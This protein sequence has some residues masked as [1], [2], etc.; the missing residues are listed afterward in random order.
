MNLTPLNSL[1]ECAILA[2]SLGCTVGASWE[3]VGSAQPTFIAFLRS[4]VPV[5][6][7]TT[8]YYHFPLG[9]GHNLSLGRDENSLPISAIP[10]SWTGKIGAVNGVSVKT[11]K[12]FKFLAIGA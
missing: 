12:S 4:Q 2:V 7:A 11:G 8:G 3:D 10:T 1:Q 9:N 5:R 6:N